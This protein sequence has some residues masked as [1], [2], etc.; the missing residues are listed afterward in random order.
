MY[1]SDNLDTVR[2]SYMSHFGLVAF[3]VACEMWKRT[4]NVSAE[5]GIFYPLS[6]V[7]ECMD[8]CI[9]ERTCVAI[10]I[11]PEACSLHINASDLLSSRVTSGV[12][13]FVLD[14]SCM[15]STASTTSLKTSTTPLAL[16][17]F[18]TFR[19]IVF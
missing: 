12:S 11:W 10:D 17:G 16:T 13:Q 14:R 15:V 7:A 18:M 5:N 3:I 6:S 19:V 4:D 9:S 8:L 2:M 1:S